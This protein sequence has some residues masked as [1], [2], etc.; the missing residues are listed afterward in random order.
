MFYRFGAHGEIE[1]ESCRN[2]SFQMNK[3]QKEPSLIT[4][5]ELGALLEDRGLVVQGRD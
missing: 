1:P 4:F 5:V 3:A 2:N